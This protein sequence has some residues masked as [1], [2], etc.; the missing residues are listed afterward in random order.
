MVESVFKLL[1]VIL[2][3]NYIDFYILYVIADSNIVLSVFLRVIIEKMFQEHGFKG[4]L[5]L[6]VF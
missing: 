2:C 4:L 1:F 3:M 6:C 5:L